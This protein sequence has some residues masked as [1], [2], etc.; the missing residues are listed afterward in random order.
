MIR[1]YPSIIAA[2][3]LRLYDTLKQLEPYC[4]GF[5]CDIMDNHFVPNLTFGAA[6]ANA[7]D[8]ATS[9]Q[10]WVHL[11][12][13]N[14]LEWCDSLTLKAGSLISFHYETIK[15]IKKMVARIQ[16][17]KWQPSIAINPKTA[18]EE[19]FPFL[20]LIDHV[21]LMSVEPG[22]AGQPF[23]PSTMDKLTKLNEYRTQTKRSFTIAID[24]GITRTNI[25]QLAQGGAHD[26]AIA[27]AIFNASNP[28]MA[29]QELQT[30]AP[31]HQ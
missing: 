8:A 1:L 20:H 21:L 16:E 9:T 27:S 18:V 2:N 30:I 15:D 26:F 13:D 11:M 4:A 22:F 28:V 6:T 17:K 10:T 14:P 19:I 25:G 5:H 3:P 24:G 29:L 7:V 23:L 31:A 12:V